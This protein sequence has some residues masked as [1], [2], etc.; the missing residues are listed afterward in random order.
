MVVCKGAF[1]DAQDP[2]LQTTV[3]H[4]I[5]IARVPDCVPLLPFEQLREAFNNYTAATTAVGLVRLHHGNTLFPDIY[6]EFYGEHFTIMGLRDPTIQFGTADEFVGGYLICR[7]VNSSNR[8]AHAM[9]PLGYVRGATR[10]IPSPTYPYQPCGT[11]VLGEQPPVHVVYMSA[12]GTVLPSSQR[13]CIGEAPAVQWSF[14]GVEVP[15]ILPESYRNPKGAA[16][17][18]PGGRQ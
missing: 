1:H 10:P 7:H 3:G 14:D 2:K 11:G 5:S 17:D 16:L 6:F 13:F 8:K 4:F 9:L 15:W 12:L 18:F